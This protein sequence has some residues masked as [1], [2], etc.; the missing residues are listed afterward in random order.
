MRLTS[1][2]QVLTAVVI[3]GGLLVPVAAR[4]QG[5]PARAWEPRGFDFSPNGVWR[6][7]AGA[8]RAL[9]EAAMARGDFT[10][11]NAALRATPN[12]LQPGAPAASPLAVTGV[13]R[14]PIFLVAYKNSSIPTLHT[15]AEY[16]ATLL[17]ATP[18]LGRPFT[19][20]T[21]YEQMSNGLLSVQGVVIGWVQLDS[22]DT[23]YEGNQNGL[24][25]SGH[26]AQLI[27][28]AVAKSDASID[29]G[30][31]DNDG[32]D[33]IPNSGD[34]DGEVDVA[35]FIHPERDGACGSN[36]NIW[37]HRFVYSG[38]TGSVLQTADNKA[39]SGKI[40]VNNYTIQSGVG[41]ATACDASAIMAPGTAAHETGHGL[42]LPDF[43]DT[44]P[45]DA[46]N[47][48]GIGHWGLM[49]SGNY[50]RPPSP[51]H[52][53][54]FSRNQLGWV[55]VVDLTT[56]GTYSLGP[57]TVGDTIFR[58]TP[59]GSNP[60][61][62]YFLL[63]NRQ[64]TLGDT[65]LVNAKGPGLLIW[66]VDPVQYAAGLPSNTVN[67]G[68]IHGLN[69]MQADGLDNLGSSAGPPLSNR[70][71]GGDPFPGTSGNTSFS[72]ATTPSVRL[73]NGTIP[74]FRVDSIRQVVV[75]GEMRFRYSVGGLTVVKGSDTN[76]VIRV[77]GAAYNVYRDL[78]NTGDTLTISADSVQNSVDDRT[79]YLFAS[80]SDAGARTHVATMNTAGLTLTAALNRRFKVQFGT[81]GAGT[82]SASGAT[83]SASFIPQ[84]DSVTLT[85]VPGTGA[86][87]VG[88]TGDTTTQNIALKLVMARPYQVVANFQLAL[89][90]QDSALRGAVMGV[91]YQDTVFT[92]G[93]TGTYVFAQLNGTLPLGLQLT[94]GGV[95]VGTPSK[96]STFTFTVRVISGQQFL[97]LPLRITVTA[98]TLLVT[99]VVTQLL[100]G[101]THLSANEIAYLDLLGNH[102]GQYDVGDFTAWLD[103]TGTV[104]SAEIMQRVMARGAR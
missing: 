5:S 81:S 68:T 56:S 45:S 52:M 30:Q 66:H 61:N 28:E 39:N 38:W 23:W 44:N 47:S 16:D 29:Y 42:G 46:D 77:R 104:V 59:T 8:V 43:Y 85:A 24:T 103:K 11:L 99:N 19:V 31:F 102:N 40:R 94:P 48:E 67:S 76:A 78:F 49:G 2:H 64:A 82:V 18:T 9:R 88:W 89:A 63:E 97:D 3:A 32:A 70:G 65:A 27:Q 20:R 60:R 41:G 91:P 86:S 84:G 10:S 74:P 22:N 101:G 15:P 21:F 69:L 62:E 6:R 57:Y 79:Q 50:A 87:F 4:A 80:W 51:A 75:G 36:S 13:L 14:V 92:I 83:P 1:L 96:D 58:I 73:N 100:S 90:V 54:G 93:G 26:V 12:L 25:Q 34:D 53:E 71:D 98:P 95:L 72:F 7:R 17:G 35:V 37:S 55:T 33:G